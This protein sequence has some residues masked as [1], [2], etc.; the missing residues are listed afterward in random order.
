MHHLFWNALQVLLYSRRE[1]LFCCMQVYT[2]GALVPTSSSPESHTFPTP[3]QTTCRTDPDDPKI[4]D[5]SSLTERTG[6]PQPLCSAA[7]PLP[8]VGISPV[9]KTPPALYKQKT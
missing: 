7:Q 1:V 6:P 4:P 3:A 9:T 2:S 5:G 8:K